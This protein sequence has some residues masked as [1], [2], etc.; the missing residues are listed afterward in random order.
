MC[1]QIDLCEDTSC[2]TMPKRVYGRF[3]CLSDA[4]HR[5]HP[6]FQLRRTSAVKGAGQKIG[7]RATLTAR[8]FGIAYPAG[9]SRV[10]SL[11]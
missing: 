9:V 3:L 5:R 6:Q 7:V 8:R 10:L 2:W 1:D 4:S 11:V